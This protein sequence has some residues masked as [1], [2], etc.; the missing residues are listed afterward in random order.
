VRKVPRSGFLV[1]L[2]ESARSTDFDERIG[3]AVEPQDD[4]ILLA[5]APSLPLLR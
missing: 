4:E 1:I 2:R 3:P 5:G